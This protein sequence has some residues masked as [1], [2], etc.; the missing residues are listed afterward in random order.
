MNNALAQIDALN[1]LEYGTPTMI[2]EG[3][4]VHEKVV[5]SLEDPIQTMEGPTIFD[6]P[7]EEALAVESAAV[8]V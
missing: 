6:E 2:E 7:A 3:V 5:Q 4:P 8:P 1:E